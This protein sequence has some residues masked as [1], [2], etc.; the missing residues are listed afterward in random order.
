MPQ[1]QACREALDPGQ[2]GEA[3]PVGE[4]GSLH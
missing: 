1:L 4:G 3:E 2:G